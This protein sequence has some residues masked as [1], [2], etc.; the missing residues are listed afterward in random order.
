MSS[1][2]RVELRCG[3]YDVNAT[4][5]IPLINILAVACSDSKVRVYD[6]DAKLLREFCAHQ[7]AVVVLL[8]LDDVIV[9]SIDY[10]GTL[11]TWN[12][13]PDPRLGY[14][15]VGRLK[16]T[17]FELSKL[18]SQAMEIGGF[19]LIRIVT[20]ESGRGLSIRKPINE[21]FGPRQNRPSVCKLNGMRFAA[22]SKIFV[23]VFNRTGEVVLCTLEHCGHFC[24]ISSCNEFLAVACLSGRL[25]IREN[26]GDYKVIATMNVRDFTPKRKMPQV[27]QELSFASSR[28][29]MLMLPGHRISFFSFRT[30]NSLDVLDRKNLEVAKHLHLFWEIL[31]YF[32]LEKGYILYW[33]YHLQF[34]AI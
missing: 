17:R 27:V 6:T 34:N 4:L 13:S 30:C 18:N 21:D 26:R 33:T 2:R 24:R 15:G 16:R 9:A 25:Y 1:T 14:I 22:A 11:C 19:N 28:L 8:H 23:E 29:L 10:Q 32:S 7:R 31:E 12:A 20:H 5:A 3:K